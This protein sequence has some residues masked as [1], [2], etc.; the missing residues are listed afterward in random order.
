MSKKRQLRRKDPGWHQRLEE[1]EGASPEILARCVT[2]GLD[3]CISEV[4]SGRTVFPHS[5]FGASAGWC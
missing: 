2:I 5:N 4:T 3:L 1:A